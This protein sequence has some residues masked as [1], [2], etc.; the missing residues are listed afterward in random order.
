MLEGMRLSELECY[1]IRSHQIEK[2]DK[3]FLSVGRYVNR[4]AF[5]FLTISPY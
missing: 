1:T 2:L 4:V 3:K 5:F